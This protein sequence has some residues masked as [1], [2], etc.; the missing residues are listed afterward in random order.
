M[1]NDGAWSRA[2]A[3]ASKDPAFKRRLMSDPVATLKEAGVAVPD[4]LKIKVYENTPDEVHLVLP[5]NPIGG[6]VTEAELERV[7]GGLANTARPC[8]NWGSGCPGGLTL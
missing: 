2:V 4:G 1:E 5:S 3:R 7:V 6:V 8:T